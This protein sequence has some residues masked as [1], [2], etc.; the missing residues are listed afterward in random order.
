MEPLPLGEISATPWSFSP[1]W[2]VLLALAVPG[3]AW[4]ACAWRRAFELDPNRIRR[5]GVKDMRRLLADLRRSRSAPQSRHLHA[6]LRAAARTWGVRVSA[7][8]AGQVSTALHA[9]TGDA[10][11]TS[12]W[13]DLWCATERGLFAAQAAPPQDW[14]ERASSAAAAVEM[15]QR[16][17]RFPNRLSHWLPAIA[18]TLLGV[19]CVVPSS[20]QAD[21]PAHAAASDPSSTTIA[22]EARE[23]AKKALSAHWNDWAAHHNVAAAGIQDGEW[24]LAI[25]HAIAS[26]LQHPSSAATRDTLRVALEQTETADPRLRR[27]L[28]GI[29]YER[30]PA[31]LSAA[32]WQRLA[33]ASAL[34]IAVALTAI[35][36][37]LYLPGRARGRR[38]LSW[39]GRGAFAAGTLMFAM[40]VA[41]WNAY[42]AMNQPTAAILL[43]NVNL[44]PV[45]TDLVPQEET[46]PVAAGTVVL[47]RRSFLGW[48]QVAVGGNA[49][50]WIRRNAVMPFYENR[51]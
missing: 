1:L 33:L 44:S 9:I 6:W 46:S 17:T 3:I 28:A 41:S 32:G 51:S 2:F 12:R 50:G 29:W 13:R 5:S 11:L 20:S 34:I 27:M 37:S 10:T 21:V 39:A 19:A 24:N 42:G 43:Q 36:L 30:M 40:A 18:A 7:P 48:Q 45:P 23:A 38:H 8:T 49:S 25:A 35:V 26:F 47:T 14:L 22:P 16:Q 4:L 15:P 31:L